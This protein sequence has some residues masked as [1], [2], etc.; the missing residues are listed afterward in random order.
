MIRLISLIIVVI[1]FIACKN[2]SSSSRQMDQEPTQTNINLND[3]L[4][5]QF[6]SS[7]QRPTQ[8]NIPAG[9]DGIVHHYICSDLCK[10]G[11]SPNPGLCSNCGNPLAHNQTWHDDQPQS[12][13]QTQNTLG[14][15]T[16]SIPPMNVQTPQI[17]PTSMQQPPEQVNIPAGSDGIV[18]HYICKDRCTGGHSPNSGNCPNCGNRL[19]HNQAWHNQ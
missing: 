4:N 18:H 16:Q 7:D 11:H 9:P 2:D 6:E 14:Q 3:P 5:T 12:Q 17:P 8:V 10:G 13:T 1:F 19:A 15:G